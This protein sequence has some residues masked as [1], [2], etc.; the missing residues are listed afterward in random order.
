MAYDNTSGA[1]ESLFYRRL[2]MTLDGAGVDFITAD[3]THAIGQQPADCAVR[4]H[5]SSFFPK[6]LG[7]G[8]LGLG[9]AYM[10]GDY[11][12]ARGELYDLLT[13][14]LRHGMDRHLKGDF[15][16][17]PQILKIRLAGLWRGRAGNAQLHY[18]V[19]DDLFESFLD[20]SMAYSCGYA[21]SPDDSL[22]KLQEAKFDRICRKLGLSEGHRLLDIGCGFGGLLIY[23]A[24]RYGVTGVGITNSKHHAEGAARRARELQVG[25]RI[26]V[27]FG[28]FTKVRG[29]Y[30]RVVSVGMLEH[31][32][33]R[34]YDA[35]FSLLADHLEPDGVGLV[36]A[37]GVC[38]DRHDHDPF[39]QRYIFPNSYQIRLSQVS[40]HLERQSLQILDVENIVRHY[41]VTGMRWLERFR[42]NA[43]GLDPDRYD[44]RFKRMWEY[45]LCIGIAAARASDSALYQILFGKDRAADL[46]L[47]RV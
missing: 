30:D 32:A 13:L 46:P 25:N 47:Q 29:S 41:A 40:R 23:A 9:E 31:V 38:A 7:Y 3:A 28:D 12:M 16:L 43:S 2:E 24:R 8:N 14:F 45:Y 6:V 17:L 35:Y 4:V 1:S 5:N 22:E 10:D 42:G 39:I 15:R 20:D 33:P 44:E 27:N 26:E 21:L 11:E 36:H 19:G 34:R 37:I 18:D